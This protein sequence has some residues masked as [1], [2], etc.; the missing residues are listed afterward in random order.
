MTCTT[1]HK[2]CPACSIEKPSTEFNKHGGHRDKLS[3]NCRE[4]VKKL[5]RTRR[6]IEKAA[7]APQIDPIIPPISSITP[8]PQSLSKTILEAPELIVDLPGI[9]EIEHRGRGTRSFRFESPVDGSVFAFESFK[10]ARKERQ[11]MMTAF[12]QQAVFESVVRQK[13][14][15]RRN[16]E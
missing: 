15:K 9:Y 5:A 12:R 8:P 10:E 4:C 6:A 7:Q 1:T 2:T 13:T 16:Q 3:T 14:G 11:Q